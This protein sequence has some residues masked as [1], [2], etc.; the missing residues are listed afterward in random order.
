M[1]DQIVVAEVDPTELSTDVRNANRG[2]PRGT[3]MI[4]RS[5]D[6]HGGGRGIV[7]DRK[8]RAIGG[9]KSLE[10]A[11]LAGLRLVVID[12]DGD[13]LVVN[14]RTDLDLDDP[15]TGARSLAVAD[16]RTAQVGL[17]WD[18]PILAEDLKDGLD[19]SDWFFPDELAELTDLSDPADRQG[20]K[21]KTGAGD[22]QVF[23]V[24][25][26]LSADQVVPFWNLVQTIADA[27]NLDARGDFVRIILG[28]LYLLGTDWPAAEGRRDV[29][30]VLN[31]GR[32]DAPE[33]GEV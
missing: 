2:T 12:T 19:L 24:E 25:L 22:A 20:K 27:A 10:A 7:V 16:N 9:N 23:R 17:L 32:L 4:A 14:R 21:P 6:R 1:T 29:L 26:I 13:V 8:G 30:S 31:T 11:V 15:A 28:A 18:G 33:R 3:F 5:I